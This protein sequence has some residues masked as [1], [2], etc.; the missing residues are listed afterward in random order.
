VGEGEDALVALCE[1]LDNGQRSR[2]RE[3]IPNLWWRSEAGAIVQGPAAAFVKDLDAAPL[4]GLIFWR[5][6]PAV[7]WHLEIYN[8][9]L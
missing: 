2:P 4:Q 5:A 8:I 6:V 9:R 1:E 7:M 3:E